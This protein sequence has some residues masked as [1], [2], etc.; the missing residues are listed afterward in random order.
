VI[1]INREVDKSIFKIKVHYKGWKKKFDEWMDLT[2]EKNLPRVR[3]FH[4]V[5]KRVVFPHPRVL[6]P[7][8]GA[9][10][11][12]LDACDKWYPSTV[13]E[14]NRYLLK[15]HYDGW[16]ESFDEWIDRDSYRIAPLHSVTSPKDVK[17]TK[18]IPTKKPGSAMTDLKQDDETTIQQA[19]GDHED[20]RMQ[21]L[22]HFDPSE[23]DEAR[24]KRIM[25]AKEWEI[26]SMGTDGS[27]LFRSISHQIYGTQAHHSE[28]RD[29]YVEYLLSERAYFR[30]FISI[31]FDRYCDIM[32][33]DGV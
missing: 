12:C 28:I 19:S 21:Y 22:S 25:R 29:K 8:I 23:E 32:R 26:V 24:F 11:D 17:S 27:C 6:Y 16:S 30:D 18:M 1:A 5:T 4:S 2:D 10:I 7:K 14:V 9:R 15:V 20:L 33:R 3:P 13:V 31:D